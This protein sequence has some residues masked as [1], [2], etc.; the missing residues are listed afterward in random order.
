M[1]PSILDVLFSHIIKLEGIGEKT[2]KN[3]E[4]LCGPRIKDL[5]FHLPAYYLDRRNI[6]TSTNGIKSG[7]YASLTL[8]VVEHISAV[9]YSKAPYKVICTEGIRQVDLIFFGKSAETYVKAI[10]P[11]NKK[12]IVNGKV[13]IYNNKIQITHPDYIVNISSKANIPEIEPVYSLT[14]GIT[15]RQIIKAVKNAASLINDIPEWIDNGVI[16]NRNWRPWK[17]SIMA[18]HKPNALQ[19]DEIELYRDRL[20]YDELFSYQLVLALT[21]KEKTIQEGI[22][23]NSKSKFKEKF[24]SSLPF[25]LTNGQIEVSDEIRTDMGSRSRMIRLLQGDVGSGKTVISIIAALD[26]IECGY[27]VAIMAPTEILSQ[28][29]AVSIEKMISDA[30]MHNDIKI[31]LLTGKDKG[32]ARKAKLAKIENGEVNIVV[33]THALFQEHVKFN[34]LGL[35]VIDEQ[36]RFGVKQ[37]LLLSSKGNNIDLLLMSATP[38]PRTL[39]LTLYGDM[40]VSILSEKPSTRKDIETF[41]MP[42]MRIS[43]IIENLQNPISKG[44]KIYWIC[45]LVEENES[46]ELTAVTD[47]LDSLQ[48]IYGEKVAMVHGKMKAADKDKA[49]LEFKDGEVSILV[50]T[51][52]VE[53]GVDVPEATV[54]IIENANQFGL[55]QL[56]QLRGRV[57]RG[58][59][60]SSCILIYSNEIS[61]TGKKR[62]QIMRETND[63]FK[64]AE[65]DLN[66]RGG[67]D[68]LG[69]KQSGMPEF[70]FADIMRDKDI[71]YLARDNV[72]KQIYQWDSISIEQKTLLLALL[73]LF[74][75]DNQMQLLNS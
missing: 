5:I 54:I 40:D 46:S 18:M 69:T 64:I 41:I 35:A 74:D 4:R 20:V 12:M 11:V 50:A 44:E 61:E 19:Y 22:A 55:S 9:R 13:Y 27:Q 24:I 45:P 58:E 8:D 51:T 6:K 53:V 42:K 37:R 10:L 3:Y 16:K 39:T 48:K 28:Q 60:Q 57:G 23:F 32:K 31:I 63:G 65:E 72:K 52:V 25:K 33:G 14:K 38:I 15:N 47:R 26:A 43:N 73:Y 1:R 2:F 75:Y 71:L 21:K 36:H 49:M 68:I 70:V 62:L 66:I 29:H 67:G 30:N 7:E 34:N 17:E 56:H 59:R